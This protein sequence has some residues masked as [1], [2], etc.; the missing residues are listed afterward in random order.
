MKK[1]GHGGDRENV[2]RENE[3]EEREKKRMNKNGDELRT[4]Y[5]GEKL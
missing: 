2:R 5:G 1:V 4:I 3:K